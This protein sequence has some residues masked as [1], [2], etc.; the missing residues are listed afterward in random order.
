[1]ND[2]VTAQRRLALA[3]GLLWALVGL[4][5]ALLV[6][7]ILIL[8]VGARGDARRAREADR[9]QL[10]NQAVMQAQG[11]QL[12]RL[13][14]QVKQILQAQHAA[15]VRRSAVVSA[16]IA[17]LQRR[18]QQQLDEMERRM[19]ARQRVLLAQLLAL[20]PPG[21]PV[22]V[23]VPVPT[24]PQPSPRP[25]PSPTPARCDPKGNSGKCR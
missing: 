12:A 20:Q 3:R 9:Q 14:E 21:T 16:A 15:D 10:A 18:E 19:L 7:I 8:L 11:E 1:M 17:E 2:T 13:T 25:A 22:P 4:V 5:V 6:A 23:L 24:R